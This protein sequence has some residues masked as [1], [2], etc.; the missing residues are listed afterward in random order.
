MEEADLLIIGNGYDVAHGLPTRYS[1]FLMFCQAFLNLY[2]FSD[3]Y[4]DESSYLDSL[5]LDN[6]L[7]DRSVGKK[8]CDIFNN[9][10]VEGKTTRLN[11]A[12]L[13]RLHKDL[14]DNFWLKY[15]WNVFSQKMLRGVNWVDFE[16]ELE[17][18]IRFFDENILKDEKNASE[19][20]YSF[21]E[22]YKKLKMCSYEHGL[23]NVF[24]EVFDQ[25]RDRIVIRPIIQLNDFINLLYSQLLKFTEALEIY[26]K[27]F[28]ESLNI[29][30]V[31]MVDNIKP[32]HILSFN[33]TNTFD[34]IS[35]NSNKG[36]VSYIHGKCRTIDNN[37]TDFDKTK[38]NL[39][40]GIN[41]YQDETERN[42]NNRFVIF[43]KFVQR[44]RN[45][46]DISYYDLAK[47]YRE[48]YEA[49][50]NSQFGKGNIP[51]NMVKVVV[52]GHS[53]DIT[54]KDI[55]KLFLKPDWSSVKIIAK[56]YE[57]EGELIENLIKI[58]SEEVVIQKAGKGMLKIVSSSEGK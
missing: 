34:R 16:C 11:E 17:K 27:Y 36:S 7:I 19:K 40:L 42:Q 8:L 13:E 46:N 30:N 33:Y 9:R 1:D 5:I 26:L 3:D 24:C 23:I 21:V 38:C 28:V 57:A 43:K 55:L 6:I 29:T 39:V 31:P 35:C 49:W 58:V 50:I 47:G 10:I 53:L 56:D 52:F 41:E 25:L 15:F 45:N 14:Q 44:I 2:C 12:I 32:H 4:S 54:D 37:T 48:N 22:F 20:D 18:I 51:K